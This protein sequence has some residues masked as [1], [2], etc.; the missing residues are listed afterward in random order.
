[1]FHDGVRWLRENDVL[2]PG[3]TTLTRL[4]ARACDQATQRLY[5]TLAEI[6]T[7]EQRLLLDELLDV[8][9]GGRVSRWERWRTGPVKASAPGMSAVLAQC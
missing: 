9:P 5:T 2:L 3:I 6:P 1:M 7:K 4:V 8:E